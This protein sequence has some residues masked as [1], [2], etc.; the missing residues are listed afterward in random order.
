MIQAKYCTLERAFFWGSRKIVS[1]SSQMGVLMQL[2]QHVL[3]TCMA[4]AWAAYTKTSFD[5]QICPTL[6]YILVFGIGHALFYQTHQFCPNFAI[7]ILVDPVSLRLLASGAKF[8]VLYSFCGGNFGF[9]PHFS[10]YSPPPPPRWIHPCFIKT[11]SRE[12]SKCFK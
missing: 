10:A 6:Q 4:H 9:L 5:L 3:C 11:R 12:E 1:R 2:E 7:Y 8:C